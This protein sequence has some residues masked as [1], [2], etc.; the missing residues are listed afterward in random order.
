[1]ESFARLV[2]LIALARIAFVA[3]CVTL[4]ITALD[5]R[6]VDGLLQARPGLPDSP[7]WWAGLVVAAVGLAL[8]LATMLR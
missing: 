4:V 2:V 1:M 7:L 6:F 3:L 8:H 5:H